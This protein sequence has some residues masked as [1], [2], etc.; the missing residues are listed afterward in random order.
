MMEVVNR[1]G[2]PFLHVSVGGGGGG[3]T[4]RAQPSREFGEEGRQV[5]A[6]WGMAFEI[7]V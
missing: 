4:A 5:T 2:G 3:N 7:R 6:R 1:T